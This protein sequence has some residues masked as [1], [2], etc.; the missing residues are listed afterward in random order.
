[1]AVQKSQLLAVTT[2][3]KNCG[4]SRQAVQH[5]IANGKLTRGKGLAK[6]SKGKP[7]KIKLIAAAKELLDNLDF[8]KTKPDL[9]ARLNV[10]AGNKIEDEEQPEDLSPGK[11]TEELTLIE[12]KRRHEVLKV[13]IKEVELDEKLA[14]LVNAD[15][16]KKKLFDYGAEIRKAMNGISKKVVDDVRASET[17]HEGVLIIDKAISQAL[18]KIVDIEKRKL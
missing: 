5:W 4:V 3:A 7:A 8:S 17:R 2:F 12:A 11:P 18:Q 14:V 1:M 10:L 13:K 6:T 9:Q 16:V 15:E